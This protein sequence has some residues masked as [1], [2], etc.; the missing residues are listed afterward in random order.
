MRFN[1]TLTGT[2]N[3]YLAGRLPA[4]GEIEVFEVGSRGRLISAV[5]RV[6]DEGGRLGAP[7]VVKDPAFA[8]DPGVD[9]EIAR[10]RGAVA[11]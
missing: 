1:V 6:Q 10:A 4:R 3:P 7:V 5:F 11:A 2:S 8:Y 9:A